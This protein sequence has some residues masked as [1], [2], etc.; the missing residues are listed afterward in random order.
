M[1]ILVCGPYRS[2]STALFNLVRTIC[3]QAGRTYGTF[4]D[5]YRP[6]IAEQYEYVV[7]KAH[8][9]KDELIHLADVVFT[10]FREPDEI[11][12]SMDRFAATGGKE[13]GVSDMVRSLAWWGMYQF[14]AAYSAHYNQLSRSPGNL[15]RNIAEQLSLKV[16]VKDVVEAWQAIKPPKSGYDP[17]TLLHSNH[18]TK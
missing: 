18:V 12:E 5:Q 1:H 10:I 9:Y 4:E 6:D 7:I 3:E 15:T 14:H 2:G 16:N 17:V 8:K 13:Y 11:V